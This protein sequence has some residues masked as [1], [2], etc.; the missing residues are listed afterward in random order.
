MKEIVQGRY[1]YI[2]VLL[3]VFMTI[4]LSIQR[5][6]QA[7]ILKEPGAS[8]TLSSQML[9]SSLIPYSMFSLPHTS[10]GYS[11]GG[12]D[13]G[14]LYLPGL[15]GTQLVMGGGAF[16]NF[17]GTIG[18]PGQGITPLNLGGG[19]LSNINL[20]IELSQFSPSLNFPQAINSL[21][22]FYSPTYNTSRGTYF[23]GGQQRPFFQTSGTSYSNPY[24]MSPYGMGGGMSTLGGTSYSSPY[25]MF[26]SGMGGGMSTLGGTSYSTPYGMFPS[27]MG[28]GMSPWG[29]TSYTTPYGMG[30]GMSQWGGYSSGG[31]PSFNLGG[32]YSPYTTPYN[33]PYGGSYYDR[34]A[35]SY[36]ST[37]TA[38][39]YPYG[40]FSNQ[41]YGSSS[42]YSIISG[43]ISGT[44]T[45][46]GNVPFEGA[47]IIIRSNYIQD[48]YRT[49]AAGYYRTLPFPGGTY[50]VTLV[51]PISGDLLKEKIVYA[52][53]P[54][55]CNFFDIELSG[56]VGGVVKHEGTGI[57]LVGVI[58][59]AQSLNDSSF[60]TVNIVS[61]SQGK[62]LLKLPEGDY[63]VTVTYPPEG[64][65][66]ILTIDSVGIFS[67]E[68][69]IR[70]IALPMPLLRGEVEGENGESIEDATVDITPEPPVNGDIMTDSDGEFETPLPVGSY[71]V[72][73]TAVGYKKK[74]INFFNILLQGLNYTFELDELDPEPPVIESPSE[75]MEIEVGQ[76]LSFSVDADDPDGPDDLLSY[77]IEGPGSWPTSSNPNYFYETT[78][79]DVGE[80][81]IKI[82]VSD[83]EDLTTT[84]DIAVKI[85]Y[86]MDLQLEPGVNLICYPEE[87]KTAFDLLPKLGNPGEVESILR[88]SPDQKA[89]Y[90]ENGELEGVGFLLNPQEG[91]LVYARQSVI[92]NLKI[93]SG[94]LTSCNYDLHKGINLIG[95]PVVLADE[96]S[97]YD[98]LREL[99]KESVVS[100][101]RYNGKTGEYESAYWIGGSLA[102]IDFFI[103]MGE[104]YFVRMKNEKQLHLPFSLPSHYRLR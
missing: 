66:G 16:M 70:D 97:A 57:P 95:I 85:V 52:N 1:I 36:T 65:G 47:N 94:D 58:I 79:A 90:D 6:G 41:P 62:Y 88:Y 19:G 89:S 14:G 73:V 77:S 91:Y 86:Y 2:I 4:G 10:A 20:P 71:K 72:E 22:G 7:Q 13:G 11:L 18:L 69:T 61:D 27:G 31:Y 34:S 92:V 48:S 99:D 12:G 49:D 33:A 64:G 82:T 84:R 83:A 51:D 35:G 87:N 29:G 81:I 74:T 54:I 21:F 56:S 39:T 68:N 103:R 42:T 23:P 102:G 25:G 5:V 50:S 53:G 32:N 93:R 59:T 60:P 63:K 46:T 80:H 28:G 55:V 98:F 15:S 76:N 40:F 26:P 38:G 24:G 101:C 43:Y 17:G 45:K 78:L 8:A 100:I 75:D 3:I 67:L 37:S 9:I 44:V 30:G 104:G 96:Y